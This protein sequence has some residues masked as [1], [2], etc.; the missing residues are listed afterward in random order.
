MALVAEPEYAEQFEG[1]FVDLYRELSKATLPEGG[2]ATLSG[3]ARRLF[4]AGVRASD[5]DGT[6]SAPEQQPVKDYADNIAERIVA[7]WQTSL[8]DQRTVAE[9]VASGVREGYSLGMGVS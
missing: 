9:M 4:A 6:E 2:D 3:I 8:N 7:Q 5:I 1:E